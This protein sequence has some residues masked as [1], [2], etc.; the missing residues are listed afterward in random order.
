MIELRET[1]D[2]GWGIFAVC[3]IPKG[4]EITRNIAEAF[5]HEDWP[6]VEAS[7]FEHLVYMNKD[8][9]PEFMSGFIALGSISMVNHSDSPNASVDRTDE[10]GRLEAILT[11]LREIQPGEQVLIRYTDRGRYEF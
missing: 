5:A 8:E 3:R 4:T 2:M 6:A 11:A 9:Y 7:P 1:E 10:S